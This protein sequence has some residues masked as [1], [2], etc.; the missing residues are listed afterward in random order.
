MCK[1]LLLHTNSVHLYTNPNCIKALCNKYMSIKAS[2]SFT[3]KKI[4]T[5]VKYCW[6]SEINATL[7]SPLLFVR[8]R[9]VGNTR[10]KNMKAF[11]WKNLSSLFCETGYTHFE[12]IN[13]REEEADEAEC[14]N[15]LTYR[16]GN[17]E[18]IILQSAHTQRESVDVEGWTIAIIIT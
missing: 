18:G 2:Q 5:L 10:K 13:I 16:A 9:A 8:W 7:Q 14:N 11:Q 6:E 1:V 17:V 12:I 15:P 4:L 3:A